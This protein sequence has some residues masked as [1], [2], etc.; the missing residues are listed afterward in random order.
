LG[1]KNGEIRQ[2]DRIVRYIA[3]YR[4]S[5]GEDTSQEYSGKKIA[6]VNVFD[7]IDYRSL[8]RDLYQERK[9]KQPFF[10]YRYIGQKVGF[11]S[12]GY[13][14]NIIQGK[15]NISA[16]LIFRFAELFKFN[17]KETEYFETLVLYDQAKQHNQKKYHYEKILATIKSE[18][19]EM[20]SDQYEYF[21]EWYYVAVREFLGFYQFKG[22]YNEL[23]RMINP[24]ITPKQAKNAIALL[25]RLGLICKNDG[26]VYS[27]TDSAITSYPQIPL[28][29]VHNFQ[30]AT[31][32]L[33][34]GS[35][36]RFHRNERSISTLSYSISEATYNAIDDKLAEF[37]KEIRELV[38]ND[39]YGSGMKRVYQ[40]NFQCFPLSDPYQEDKKK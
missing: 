17:K 30:L 2:K 9:K 39:D 32:D 4:F 12:A 14:T 27:V 21:N 24:P 5:V 1:I 25:E 40:L 37:R 3:G 18:W 10:S 16:D 35:I 7:Y 15:R 23:S 33:A 28:V 26:G 13:F 8:L 11:K 31:L 29:A 20:V 34:K 19:H 36:D 6:M 22:D 38:K